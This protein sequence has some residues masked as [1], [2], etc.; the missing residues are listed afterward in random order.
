MLGN[1]ERS[2]IVNVISREGTMNGKNTALIFGAGA[3]ACYEDGIHRIPALFEILAPFKNDQQTRRKGLEEKRPKHKKRLK[4]MPGTRG[5]FS[6]KQRMLG[7]DSH[8]LGDLDIEMGNVMTKKKLTLI[9]VCAGA[10]YIPIRLFLSKE[11]SISGPYVLFLTLLAILW[12]SWETSQLRIQQKDLMEL[13]LK[14]HLI[15]LFQRADFVLYNI[16]YGPA[17][18]IRIDDVIV[19]FPQMPRLRL[20]FTCPPVINKGERLPIEIKILTEDE[21][22]EPS[23][24]HLGFLRPPTATET[25]D[26]NVHFENL[27]SKEYIFKLKIG[28][29]MPTN[30]LPVDLLLQFLEEKYPKDIINSNEISTLYVVPKERMKLIQYCIE[31]LL[32]SADPIQTDQDGIIDW[33]NIRITSEGIDYLK[34]KQTI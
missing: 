17:V 29:D 10:V 25:I 32:V 28:K 34:G 22:H 3:S 7:A 1:G 8:H 11:L 27:T 23:G 14:P 2:I 13:S 4:G 15:V 33:Y 26:I 16:G 21:K 31:K 6:V 5:G 20:R 19:S 30:I 9:L 18:R 24:F 12:Y